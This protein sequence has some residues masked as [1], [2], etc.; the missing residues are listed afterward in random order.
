MLYQNLT[1]FITIRTGLGAQPCVQWKGKKYEGGRRQ[2]S[3]FCRC[4]HTT[5]R[6][7]TPA[8]SAW[9]PSAPFILFAFPLNSGLRPETRTYSDEFRQNLI[10]HIGAASRTGYGGCT[11]ITSRKSSL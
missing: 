11:P 10:Q 6:V 4:I 2:P 5:R 1:K 3:A 8:K 7:D 9:L